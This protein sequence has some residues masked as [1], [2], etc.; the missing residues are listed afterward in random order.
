MK[1]KTAYAGEVYALF[2][3]EDD[4]IPS[5]LNKIEAGLADKIR[6][7]VEAGRFRGKSGQLYECAPASGSGPFKIIL[8]GTGKASETTSQTLEAFGALAVKHTLM[9]GFKTLSIK[10]AGGESDANAL[11]GARLAAYRFDTYFTKL[12]DDQK[13]S[14]ET[15]VLVSDDVAVHI[16]RL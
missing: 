13:P 7:S 14:L 2:T 15:V 3:H 16:S 11:L 10:G 8:I 6:P 12:K 1:S 4:Y 5:E 9:S